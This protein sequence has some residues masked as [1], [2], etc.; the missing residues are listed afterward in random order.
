MASSASDLVDEDADLNPAEI[1]AVDTDEYRVLAR[2]QI[3]PQSPIHSDWST[4]TITVWDKR[5]GDGYYYEV[6]QYGEDTV[7]VDADL[8]THEV[9]PLF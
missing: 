1:D 3:I 6:D 5:E 9:L 8:P 7:L 2:R 4:L